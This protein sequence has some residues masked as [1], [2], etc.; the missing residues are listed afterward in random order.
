MAGER[1]VGFIKQVRVNSKT[2]YRA[3]IEHLAYFLQLAVFSL[4][5]KENQVH[6]LGDKKQASKN[7]ALTTLTTMLIP[8]FLQ[9]ATTFVGPAL[10]VTQSAQTA[11]TNTLLPRLPDPYANA[12]AQPEPY[13]TWEP[14]GQP[15]V[16]AVPPFVAPPA[17]PPTTAWVQQPSPAPAPAPPPVPAPNTPTWTPGVAPAVPTPASPHGEPAPVV[18]PPAAGPPGGVVV[19][20]SATVVLSPDKTIIVENPAI[21]LPPYGEG[22]PPAGAAAA[23]TSAPPGWYATTY[24]ACQGQGGCQWHIQ[25]RPVAS[26]G[27]SWKRVHGRGLIRQLLSALGYG[28]L[29][30]VVVLVVR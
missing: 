2:E 28:M 11:Q 25:I 9:V 7:T 6:Y 18:A 12:N 29:T 30:M 14:N 4:R 15:S 17:A 3:C 8:T 22:G 20:G 27:S 5:K 21:T 24:Y 13:T 26:S 23:W 16:V 19:G 1:I 10:T